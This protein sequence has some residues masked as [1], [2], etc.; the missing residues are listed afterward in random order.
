MKQ[1]F[2]ALALLLCGLGAPLS[3]ETATDAAEPAATDPAAEEAVL[4]EAV[5]AI[6]EG[7]AAEAA[8]LYRKMAT[9]GDGAAQ[10][11]LGLLYFA[12]RGVP[13]SHRDALYWA[14]RARLSGVAA[15]PAL[16]A[17]MADVT[18]PALQKELAQRL[19]ADLQPRIDAG[20][21]RAMLEL[22]GVFLEVL[23]EPDLNNA[24]IWQALAAALEV[25][26]AGDAR[27]LT[28]KRMTAEERLKSEAQAIDVLKDL[29]TKGL[30]GAT[31][32]TA[33]F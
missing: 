30:K 17:K 12:G 13:Q 25:P 11:N 14:W 20:E 32:C 3:A 19:Q 6:R 24:F 33:M 16:I 2:A 5:T 22:S 15:A 26:G 8:A 31:L 4:S 7:R 10:F 18:T 29:C 28:G 9:D 27:D 1:L 21:G 23:P